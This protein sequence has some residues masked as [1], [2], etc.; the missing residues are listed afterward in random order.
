ML[1]C[2]RV[3]PEL[4][5]LFN[6]LE[7]SL[8]KLLDTNIADYYD[9]LNELYLK[10]NVE[11]FKDG[12]IDYIASMGTPDCQAPSPPPAQPDPYAPSTSTHGRN[13]IVQIHQQPDESSTIAGENS[14]N[15]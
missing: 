10:A 5:P 3:N 7:R 6:E 13:T 4:R 2:W 12:Q 1:S 15:V 8:S 9:K 11:K 14:T